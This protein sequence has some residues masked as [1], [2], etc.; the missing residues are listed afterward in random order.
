MRL[1]ARVTFRLEGANF[2]T[3]VPLAGEVDI[4]KKAIKGTELM[5]STLKHIVERLSRDI[6]EM[7][8]DIVKKLMSKEHR[9]SKEQTD[10]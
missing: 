5:Q 3:V 9:L 1:S 8:D 10:A 7:T 4:N 2:N 6:E